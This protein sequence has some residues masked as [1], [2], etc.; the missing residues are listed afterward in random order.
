MEYELLPLTLQTVNWEQYIK[1]CLDR[2]DSSPT[3]CLDNIGMEPKDPK[4][5]YTTLVNMF[6]D[7]S[8]KHLYYSFLGTTSMDT[9]LEVSNFT[10]LKMT[11]KE[12]DERGSFIF[13]LSGTLC[14]WIT[15]IPSLCSSGVR[16]DTKQLG[17][18][19]LGFLEIFGLK[20][21]WSNYEKVYSKDLFI[22]K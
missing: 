5:Y 3:R 4:A 20:R 17:N 13:I 12:L 16:K 19:C 15:A 10:D 11:N 7:D 6:G 1:I 8:I 14:Q 9:L 2:L 21:Y 22:L 18:R